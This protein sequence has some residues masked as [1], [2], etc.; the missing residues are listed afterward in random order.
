MDENENENENENEH[1]DNE[2]DRDSTGETLEL[3][4]RDRAKD[5]GVILS[6]LD[7][8][9]TAIDGLRDMLGTYRAVGIDNDATGSDADADT[10]EVD[11]AD[12]DDFKGVSD[13][14]DNVFFAENL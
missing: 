8:I 6:R 5:F 10:V 13:V 9:D 3:S 1:D 2:T 4:Y 7:M 11:V 12:A 14:P